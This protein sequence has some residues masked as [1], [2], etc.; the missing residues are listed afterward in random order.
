MN[1]D[2]TFEAKLKEIQCR[3]EQWREQGG[4]RR[5]PIPEPLW[6][7]AAGLAR[8]HGVHIVARTLRLDYIR[9]KHRS[10]GNELRSG[11]KVKSPFVEVL[12]PGEGLSSG[13]MVELTNPAGNRMAI[14]FPTGS[15]HHE[16][17]DLA[18]V[19]LRPQR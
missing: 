9:L 7:A 6:E 12:C 2:E 5:R 15:H 16:L 8:T 19:F 4:Q 10:G 18:K 1:T 14:R 17:L 3:F 13:C 11:R